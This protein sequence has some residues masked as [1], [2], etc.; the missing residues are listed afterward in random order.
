MKKGILLFLVLLSFIGIYAQNNI[1]VKSFRAL[2]MDRAA[3]SLEG[4]RVDQNGQVA[5]LIKVVTPETGFFFE[6]GSLGV[7]DTKQRIGEIWVW[8][9]RGLR[10]ITV[11]HQQLGVLR[12]YVFPVEI[13]AESTYEMVLTTAKIETVVKEQV[14]E[15]YLMFQITPPDAILEVD[16]KVWKVS[17]EGTA[18]KLVD[19]GTYSYRVQAPNYYPEAG[20]VTVNDPNDTKKIV[21][22]LRPNFGWIEV[23]SSA[24]LNGAIVYVDNAMIG[25]APCK[26]GPLKSGQ[27]SVKIA[28]E[29]YDTY[30]Q[31]VT[32]NDNE[33]VKVSPSLTANF[34]HVTLQVDADAEIWV[35]DERKGIRTWSGDL[36]NGSYIMECKM[37]NHEPTSVKKEISNQM[38]GEVIRLEAPHPINGSLVVES[39]PDMAE[40]FIDGKSYGE[41][42][43]LISEILIGT[44]ELR[45]S[46]K[47][48]GDYTTTITIEKGKRSQVEATLSNGR[49]IKF[50]C[51]VRD[52]VLEIDGQRVG[53]ASG[54]Y[55]LTYGQHNLK[56]LATNYSDYV[57]ELSVTKNS[58]LGYNIIMTGKSSCPQ[59]AVPGKFSISDNTQV[60][61]S[62]GNLQYQASTKTWRFAE[63]QWD[64]IGEANKNVSSSYQGW[65]DLFCW[66]TS[67][68]KSGANCYQ[69]WSTSYKDDYLIGGDFTNNLTGKYAN[70]DWG[71]YNA[72]SNGGNKAGL[73]R[74]MTKDEWRYLLKKRNTSSGVLFA[75]ACVNGVNGVIILPDDWKVSYYSLRNTNIED[76]SF[77]SNSIT[78][79]QWTILEQQG[80]V[81]LPAAGYRFGTGVSDVGSTGR[82]W[83]VTYF[84]EGSG[85][86]MY[87]D[88]SS[89]LPTYCNGRS[90]GQAVRL[91]STTYQ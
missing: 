28:K 62:K 35:N 82:Y 81:F 57:A 77:N 72:I 14:R 68:W 34:A 37:Q 67:G 74:T 23:P 59:G 63:N 85:C 18:R 3:S 19:F 61:F 60:Y 75:K 56:A 47:G 88:D 12:D 78:I 11:L 45:L 26:S 10:K 22:T 5:A 1:S 38:N 40:L 8:V 83:S 79:S 16:D 65:I 76:A 66:G 84:N 89:L 36:E 17:N 87:F 55:F 64:M 39:E 73:W 13:E 50:T 70:A 7:V 9:P 24:V 54:T 51:N 27:H 25:K 69:P 43:K 52:A 46:K 49:E 33:T 4:K 15:Q 21:V 6:G 91:I 41:T 42:P 20:Q 58:G 29:L 86:N 2:P 90:Y 53:S 71:I 31:V 32:V 44:H 80:A 30:N 48:Y